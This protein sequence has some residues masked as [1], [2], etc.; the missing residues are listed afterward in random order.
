MQ[1]NV[2]YLNGSVYDIFDGPWELR[3]M[4]ETALVGGGGGR[5][6]EERRYRCTT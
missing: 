2:I 5:E 4:L 6:R 1:E 3:H